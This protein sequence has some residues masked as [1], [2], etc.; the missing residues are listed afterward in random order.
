[1]RWKSDRR[2]WL[3]ELAPAPVRLEAVAV[4]GNGTMG[5]LS[6]RD[7]SIVLVLHFGRFDAV[8][9]GDLSGDTVNA[10]EGLVAPTVGESEV[11][12]VHDHG[13]ATS[14][15]AAWM[16]LVHP[17][18]AMLSVGSP[19]ALAQPAQV[20][21]DRIRAAGATTYWTTAGGGAAAQAPYDIV[22][23]GT[24]RMDTVFPGLEFMVTHEGVSETYTSW[25]SERETRQ[26][27]ENDEKT[28]LGVFRPSS[29]SWFFLVSSSGY[30]SYAHH[31]WG[32]AG[33]IP[34][35]RRL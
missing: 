10:I 4:N 28:E 16:A 22:A 13:G 6:E 29:G 1:M 9:G 30:T 7:R 12:K 32:I 26:D 34:L 27:Y 8:F 20:A 19:N 31:N 15:S 2:C 23:D 5:P 35:A 17:K 33:D 14:S 24:I 11:Y 18:V 21:L 25:D 3:D